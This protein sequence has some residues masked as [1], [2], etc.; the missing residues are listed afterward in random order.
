MTQ[1]QRQAH[2]QEYAR[3]VLEDFRT[4]LLGQQGEVLPKSPLGE[5]IGYVLGQWKALIR[6][7]DH[8]HLSID[9]NASE[10]A[11]RAV[12]LG[13]KNY[14]FYGS[15]AGGQWAAILY[16]LI[17]ICKRHAVEP[18]AYLRD[19]LSHLPTHSIQQ[20]HEL[21]PQHWKAAQ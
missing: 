13:R 7:V 12:Y 18:F 17:A 21:F 14:L 8:G 19:V 11:L 6:S 15:D 4:G 3:S 5:A 16:S 10:R 2:R 9:N 1:S 20:L